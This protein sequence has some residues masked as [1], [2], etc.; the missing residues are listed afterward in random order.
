MGFYNQ[1]KPRRFS[2]RPIYYD[3]RTE[4]LRSS[5]E[6]SD[7]HRGDGKTGDGR[8]ESL[9]RAF[10]ENVR[11]RRQRRRGGTVTLLPLFVSA[12]F[13]IVVVVLLVWIYLQG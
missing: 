4:F 9:R 13:V 2:H 5:V 10:D 6:Q 8:H 12:V 11:S 1:R 3:E 7:G